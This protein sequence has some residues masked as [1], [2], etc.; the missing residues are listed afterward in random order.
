ME[1]TTTS[2]P[3]TNEIT[4]I[5]VIFKLKQKRIFMHKYYQF[6]LNFQSIV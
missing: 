3:F 6:I 1:E 2:V 4:I 5:L